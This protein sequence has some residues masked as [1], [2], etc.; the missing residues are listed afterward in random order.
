M[1]RRSHGPDISFFAFQD[2]IT[3]VV[4]IFIL[5]TII[6]VLEL[7]QRVEATAA[8]PSD[9]TQALKATLAE[10]QVETQQMRS[11]YERRLEQRR[12]AGESNAFSRSERTAEA[13]SSI[14]A[15][16]QRIAVVKEELVNLQ[17]QLQTKRQ[18]ENHLLSEL[19]EQQPLRTRLETLQQRRNEIAE[20]AEKYASYDGLIYRDRTEEGR[21]L[22]LV[23]LGQ[24]KIVIQDSA[25]RRIVAWS[26]NH[27]LRELENWLKR[28]GSTRR[29]ILLLVTPT[30]AG[31]FADTRKLLEER[32]EVFGFDVVDQDP[33]VKLRFEMEGQR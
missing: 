5:I 25:S 13:T 33:S 14:T 2:I 23:T 8:A 7:L 12:R 22:C 24:D 27:R 17:T 10:L 18:E 28:Q 16:R 3:A 4:G 1:K 29:H 20:T 19:A 11:E 9:D 26:G 31:D 15:A 32:D 6:F 21:F 30:G